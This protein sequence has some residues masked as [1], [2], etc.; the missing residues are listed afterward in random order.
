MA[1]TST[2]GVPGTKFSTLITLAMLAIEAADALQGDVSPETLPVQCLTAQTLGGTEEGERQRWA[3]LLASRLDRPDFLELETRHLMLTTLV[4]LIDGHREIKD[5]IPR[6]RDPSVR[7]REPRDHPGL[8]LI[9]TPFVMETKDAWETVEARGVVN[10]A[11]VNTSPTVEALRAELAHG[12][13]RA[14][15]TSHGNRLERRQI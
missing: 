2:Q 9:V 7:I 1:I 3:G 15:W 5:W 6:N 13:A 8:P 11:F 14:S 12:P 4:A 10:Q